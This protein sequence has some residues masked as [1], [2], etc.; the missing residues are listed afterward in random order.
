MCTWHFFF[1]PKC[2]SD[3]DIRSDQST[4]ELSLKI[5]SFIKFC[6]LFR[7]ERQYRISHIYRNDD[8]TMQFFLNILQS[9]WIVSKRQPKSHCCQILKNSKIA[10]RGLHKGEKSSQRTTDKEENGRDVSANPQLRWCGST[11][12][13]LLNTFI[14]SDRIA[15]HC[16]TFRQSVKCHTCCV[17][18]GTLVRRK[19]RSTS[20][21]YA[22]MRMKCL[23]WLLHRCQ[24]YIKARMKSE[25]KRRARFHSGHGT[26]FNL[27]VSNTVMLMIL[28]RLLQVFL[29]L[30]MW[31]SSGVRKHI[32]N[33]LQFFPDFTLELTQM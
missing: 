21:F 11:D 9:A 3:G 29:V 26:S 22:E 16:L 24:G 2:F 17:S 20:V 28:G 5:H 30:E 13:S 33:L 12:G 8:K 23:L 15:V 27:S 14:L 32:F 19:P 18:E 31:F 1:Y 25:E 6:E 4:A 7:K 10:E